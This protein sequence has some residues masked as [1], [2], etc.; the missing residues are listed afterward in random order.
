MRAAVGIGNGVG[1]AK[2]LVG[3]AVVVLHDAIDDDLVLLP[4][5]HDGL[6]MEDLLVAAE[7]A[8]KLLDALAVKKRLLL[9]LDPLVLQA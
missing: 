6:G 1:E 2:D 7:L 4:G 8:D 3:V 9:V 5:Q